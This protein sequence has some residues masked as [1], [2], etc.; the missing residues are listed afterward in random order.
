MTRVLLVVATRLY[1]EGLANLLNAHETL[2]VVGCESTGHDAL[3]R[4]EESAPDVALIDIGLPDLG[5][6]A[7]AL[8]QRSPRIPL[9]AI[10]I[11]DGDSDVVAYAEL[12]I[13]SYVQRES[14]VE[15]LTAAVQ[16]AADGELI[17]SARTAG[18]LIRRLAEIAAE[19][20]REDGTAPLTRRER[21]IATLMCED[22]SNKEIADAAPD[23]GGHGEESHSQCP[24]QIACSPPVGSHP[25]SRPFHRP[26]SGS[27]VASQADAL[28]FGSQAGCYQRRRSERAVFG[29]G[30]TT[31]RPREVLAVSSMTRTPC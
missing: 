26:L 31:S 18:V 27:R 10:G 4:L 30:E 16:A 9:V 23:R 24:R 8:A 2:T 13:A 28:Q 14:S 20:H 17:C 5:A 3:A 22:L 15:E 21:E 6:M 11:N 25:P 12:G 29:A 7:T 19:R 1:R